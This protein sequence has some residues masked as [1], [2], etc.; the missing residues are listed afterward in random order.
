MTNII[1]Q[2]RPDG[3]VQ[4]GDAID[5]PQ[6]SKYP[7]DPDRNNT[8]YDDIQ[9]YGQ[10]LNVWARE[11]RRGIFY[12]LEGNHEDRLRRYIWANASKI[13]QLVKTIPELLGIE[14][15]N[16]CGSI[17]FRWFP[18]SRWDACK[19]GD[20]VLH[21]GHFFNKHVAISNLERYPKKFICGH[22]HRLQLV[23]NGDRFSASLGHGSN[24]ALTS[25][26]PTPTGWQQAFGLLHEIGGICHLEVVSVENGKCI[27]HGEVIDAKKTK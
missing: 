7:L 22:T 18:I 6:I 11:L 19:I 4:L 14:Q 27:L 12:Q 16:K 2:I 25:H 8:V 10:Q 21:H 23:S 1:R 9:D 24:E 26:N 15:R 5:C 20:T 3:V 13:N 17:D